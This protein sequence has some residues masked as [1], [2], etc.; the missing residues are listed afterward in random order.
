MPRVSKCAHAH[1]G[2]HAH[3]VTTGKNP[4]GGQRPRL[5]RPGPRQVK[6]PQGKPVLLGP[7]RH[8]GRQLHCLLPRWCL[9]LNHRGRHYYCRDC[10]PHPSLHRPRRVHLHHI[11]CQG[12]CTH[13]CLHSCRSFRCRC[14]CHG[15]A[16]AHPRRTWQAQW[17]SHLVQ[18]PPPLRG[19]ESH[20]SLAEPRRAGGQHRT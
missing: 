17:P 10:H 4:Q 11:H 19:E 16:L 5:L 7:G 13:P 20:H 12:Y 3:T 18:H 15:Q 9:H 14:Y 2:A 6:A 8:P 1:T